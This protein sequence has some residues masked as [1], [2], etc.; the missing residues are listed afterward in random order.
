MTVDLLTDLKI[1]VVSSQEELE[2]IVEDLESQPTIG[3]DTEGTKFDPF[4]AKLLLVQIATKDKIYVI[5]VTGVDLTP[6]KHILEA[7]RPLKIVQNAKFDYSLLK[8]QAGITL[9][10]MFDTMLA[11]RIL[12]VGILR[13]N[14]F[15]LLC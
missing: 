2:K 8:A 12:T 1:K 9:G 11:E 14:F 13:G 4:T 6:I 15:C 7:E 10:S 3:L 5:D